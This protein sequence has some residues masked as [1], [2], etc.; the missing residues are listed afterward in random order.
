MADW[1][2]PPHLKT[3]CKPRRK[4]DA[5]LTPPH[6]DHLNPK[7]N[8][9]G[10]GQV[11]QGGAA[12]GCHTLSY[13]TLSCPILPYPITSYR[14]PSSTLISLVPCPA[15]LCPGPVLIHPF[16]ISPNHP[17]LPCAVMSCPILS[18]LFPSCPSICSPSPMQAREHKCMYLLF[19]LLW[20]RV[21]GLTCWP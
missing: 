5:P 16:L 10:R 17:V 12:A 4:S 19:V 13:A 11:R 7:A 1:L 20:F 18:C 6:P 15:L 3:K 14:C 21:L 9:D 8:Q 2:A